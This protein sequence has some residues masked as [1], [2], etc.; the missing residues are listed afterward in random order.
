MY[1]GEQYLG[2]ISVYVTGVVADVARN[3]LS[4]EQMVSTGWEVKFT[5]KEISLRHEKKGVMGYG[6]SWAGCPWIHLQGGAEKRRKVTFGGTEVRPME[7]DD[8]QQPMEV[9]QMQSVKTMTKKEQEEMAL[10]RMRGHI[11]FW[12]ECPHCRMTRGTTQHR[13]TK[14]VQDRPVAL[15]ADFCFINLV[16]GAFAKDQPTVPNMKVLVMT[17][18]ST[19]M[20]KKREE[21]V[22]RIR[23]R[24]ARYLYS[25]GD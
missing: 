10:F 13:R 5:R 4:T 9:D 6:V 15:Q 18:M 23:N 17:E 3:I 11:P 20:I 8:G 1:E 19:R 14:D 21:Q 24:A 2:L 7:V 25:T 12:S 16:T 22:V